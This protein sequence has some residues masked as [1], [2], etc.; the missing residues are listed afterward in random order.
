MYRDS[1]SSPVPYLTSAAPR[2]AQAE[3]G[4]LHVLQGLQWAHLLANAPFP[5]C[6]GRPPGPQ[7]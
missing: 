3:E 7:I 4:F 5:V 1:N 2:Q 6:G